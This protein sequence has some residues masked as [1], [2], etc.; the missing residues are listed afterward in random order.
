MTLQQLMA[1]TVTNDHVRQEQ[2]WDRISGFMASKGLRG[3]Q[4]S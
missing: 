2:V 1:F 4:R 3:I